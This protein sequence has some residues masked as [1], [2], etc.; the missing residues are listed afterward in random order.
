MSVH[1]AEGD[2]AEVVGEFAGGPAAFGV[3]TEEFQDPFPAAVW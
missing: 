1:G 2:V 3:G